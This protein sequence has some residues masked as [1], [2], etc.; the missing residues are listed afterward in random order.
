MSDTLERPSDGM[1]DERKFELLNQL[2]VEKGLDVEQVNKIANKYGAYAYDLCY[3]A[4]DAPAELV[5]YTDGKFRNTRFSIS[6]MAQNDL[7]Q[8]QLAGMVGYHDATKVG[9][10]LATWEK[11]KQQKFIDDT[12]AQV[13]G[14]EAKDKVTITSL[15][16]QAGVKSADF[17]AVCNEH[18]ELLGEIGGGKTCEALAKAA[19]QVVTRYGPNGKAKV[20]MCKSGVDA[21]HANAARRYGLPTDSLHSQK[22]QE[23]IVQYR[24]E[25]PY[26]GKSNGGCNLYA[27]LENSGDYVTVAVKNTAYL[28]T[29]ANT[30]AKNKEMN[31]LFIRCQPGVT[32]TI[33]DVGNRRSSQAQTAG[34]K[35]GHTA[36]RANK[37]KRQGR[38]WACDF[39]Q[40]EFNFARYGEYAHACFPKDAC[41][42]E[43]YAK[44]II[45][46][47][48]ER[49]NIHAPEQVLITTPPTHEEIKA[50][51]LDQKGQVPSAT[52]SR[53]GAFVNMKS[54]PVVICADVRDYMAYTD[55]RPVQEAL[56]DGHTVAVAQNTS[57]PAVLE[58]PKK[59]ENQTIQPVVLDYMM[60]NYRA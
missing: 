9:E 21:I 1:T 46:K 49:Q 42:S 43:E 15:M 7:S 17:Q 14:G 39:E 35:W 48:Q 58:E 47:A 30:T 53:D 56:Q 45:A 32:M 8:E 29:G 13:C 41:V 50:A 4:V 40:D 55:T 51:M 28:A 27:G 52:D 19:D 57:V 3:K 36:V 37:T 59:K 54:G 2:V 10:N 60:Q 11:S 18:P 24:R 25:R 5:D 16:K 44:M 34:G 20:G 33:D 22:S 23:A 12:Y 31:D 38:P 6:Y 26:Q